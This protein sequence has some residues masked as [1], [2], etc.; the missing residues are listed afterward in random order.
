MTI[1]EKYNWSK[2]YEPFTVEE[3]RIL[4]AKH[5]MDVS[6]L[7]GYN[8]KENVFSVI[9]SGKDR[10]FADAA[11][12]LSEKLMKVANPDG[13]KL[14]ILEDRRWEHPDVIGGNLGDIPTCGMTLE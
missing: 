4:S 13:T 12:K 7:I 1:A 6:V 9:T 5:G 14:E 8:Q 11:V 10:E 2:K 3:L